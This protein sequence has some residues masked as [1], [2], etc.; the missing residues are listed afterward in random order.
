[1]TALVTFEE[2]RLHLQMTSSDIA[3]NDIVDRVGMYIDAASDIVI[4]YIKRPD[5]GWDEVYAPPLIKAA[6]LLLIGQL[7]AIREGGEGTATMGPTLPDPVRA[8]LHRYRD[9]ALA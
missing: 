3:D 7:D 1:M 9:P 2:A 5:H 8:I 6:V 4:D